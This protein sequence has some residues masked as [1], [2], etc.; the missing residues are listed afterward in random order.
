MAHRRP[1]VITTVLAIVIGLVLAAGP[2]PAVLIPPPPLF[3]RR[4]R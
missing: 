2:F 3:P 4:N 1:L